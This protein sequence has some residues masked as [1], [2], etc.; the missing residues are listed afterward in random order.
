MRAESYDAGDAVAVDASPGEGPI[1]GGHGEVLIGQS[2]SFLRVLRKIPRLAASDATVLI[3]GDTGT[4]KELIAE[5]IHNCSTRNG[6]SFIAVN[7]GALPEELVENELFGHARGAYTGAAASGKGLLAEAEGGTLFLDEL[8]S[9]SMSAQ[10]KILRFLQNREYRMLGSTKLLRANVRIIAATNVDLRK[11]VDQSLFRAD[12]FH[13]LHVLSIELPPLRERSEDI[14][15]LA[16]HFLGKYARDYGKGKMQ[17]SVT[18]LRKL[19]GYAWYGNVRELQSVLERS[20]LLAG[21]SELQAEDIDLPSDGNGSAERE[22]TDVE[23]FTP[24]ATAGRDST[25]TFREAKERMIRQFERTY[26]IQVMA[27]AQGNVSRAARMAGM[28]RR[29]FQRL[30]RKHD[31]RRPEP[32][33]WFDT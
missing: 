17:L 19:S 32:R 14:P 31:V 9:L 21:T 1:F 20:V 27:A 3:T 22:L 28:Q 11:H 15:L 6:R 30:L 25:A 18:A 23:D 26:L 16:Q 8:N 7:C 4:G 5:A 33:G 12:L 29:D 2:P 10:A 24:E 13:R